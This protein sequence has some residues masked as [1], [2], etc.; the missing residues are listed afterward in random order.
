MCILCCIKK[1]SDMTDQQLENCYSHNTDGC[2]FAF[3]KKNKVVVRK[4]MSFKKFKK[5]FRKYQLQEPNSPFMVHFR[6]TSAGTTDRS[7]CHPFQINDEQAM[8][9]NGTIYSVPND[10]KGK[11]S[12]T[13]IF[14]DTVLKLLPK[15][16]DKNK[17]V[18]KLV[19]SFIGKNKSSVCNK[20][21]ILNSD[22]SFTI[23]NED[24]GHWKEGIWF[25]NRDYDSTSQYYI[26]Q[27]YAEYYQQNNPVK[28]INHNDVEASYSSSSDVMKKGG[29]RSLITSYKMHKS[30]KSY[31]VNKYN[32]GVTEY[33]PW[34]VDKNCAVADIQKEEEE[35]IKD[36]IGYSNP[37]SHL[38]MAEC[39]FCNITMWSDDLI[40]MDFGDSYKVCKE[41]YAAIKDT[42]HT[43]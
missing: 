9:H 26:N 19:T 35:E 2:G 13:A 8:A 40:D 20:V 6:A 30:G 24:K 10:P 34:D 36:S 37:N 31:M 16:W 32:N 25:S 15:Y 23:L 33:I 28:Y 38:L 12:D 42:E 11:R 43:T 27:Q 14:A 4:M 17:T 1:G 7:N 3:V 41:C 39:D 29:T 21:A 18:V 22:K 5:S